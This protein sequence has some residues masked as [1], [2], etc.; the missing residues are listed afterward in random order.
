M[1]SQKLIMDTFATLALQ[2]GV[3]CVNCNDVGCAYC[4]PSNEGYDAS[5]DQ[6]LDFVEGIDNVHN[7]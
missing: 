2:E 5:Y 7:V 4:G 1:A 6:W 3:C